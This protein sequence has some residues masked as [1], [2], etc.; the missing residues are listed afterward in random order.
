HLAG[1]AAPGVVAPA[2]KVTDAPLEHYG[3]LVTLYRIYKDK[4]VDG[5]DGWVTWKEAH[6]AGDLVWWGTLRGATEVTA[7][8]V[9]SL[10]CFG[11]ES[12]LSKQLGQECPD[13]W[14]AFTPELTLEDDERGFAVSFLAYPSEADTKTRYFKSQIFVNKLTST[15]KAD[16]IDEINGYISD[17]ADGSDVNLHED[18]E[19]FNDW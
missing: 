8:R 19:A 18:S 16:L 13:K 7:G 17:C 5:V 11:P 9:W 1:V 12:L 14:F 6:D 2:I 4:W 3:R 15:N 10:G